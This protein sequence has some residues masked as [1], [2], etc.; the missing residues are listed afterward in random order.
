PQPRRELLHDVDGGFLGDPLLVVARG[1]REDAS[2]QA[3]EQLAPVSQLFPRIHG[4]L[5]YTA[6]TA[7]EGHIEQVAVDDGKAIGR[8]QQPRLD[9]LKYVLPKTRIPNVQVLKRHDVQLIPRLGLR[10][11]AGLVKQHYRP[12]SPS[13]LSLSTA[14]ACL[15]RPG[16]GTPTS[17]RFSTMDSASLAR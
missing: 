4:V 9:G 17:P 15:S 5:V 7:L 16:M 1:R 3:L 13:C 14:S 12:T 2:L 8:L 10:R 11:E 6:D